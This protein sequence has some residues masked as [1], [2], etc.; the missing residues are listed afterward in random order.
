MTEI[1]ESRVCCALGNSSTRSAAHRAIS[2][3]ALALVPAAIWSLTHR[4]QGL[5]GD[6]GLYAVQA[7]ARLNT[8]LGK[9]VFLSHASQDKFTIF[10]PV[11]AFFIS[12]MGLHTAGVVLL[13]VFKTWFSV[14]AWALCRRLFGARVALLAATLLIITGG[15]YGAYQVFHYL[16]DMLTARS[17]AEALAMTA[18]CLHFYEHRLAALLTAAVAVAVHPLIALPMV[19]LL[20]CLSLPARASA[21]CALAGVGTV[22]CISV[23]AVVAPAV[24]VKWFA[25]MDPAWLDM[26]RERSQFCFLQLWSASD[27]EVNALPFLSLTLSFF[28][29]PDARIRKLIAAAMLVGGV[30][31]LIGLIAGTVGPVALLL[32]GQAWRWDW[33]T[34][35]VSV[36]F[37]APTAVCLWKTD[38]CGPLCAVLLAG[39]WLLPVDV[40]TCFLAPAVAIWLSRR[41][42]PARWGRYFPWMFAVVGIATAAMITAGSWHGFSLPA[43]GGRES[44]ALTVVRSLLCVSGLP[45]ILAALAGYWITTGRSLRAASLIALGLGT[46]TACSLPVALNISGLKRSDAQFEEYS[47]WRQVIPR[48]SNVLVLESYYSAAFAWF[49]LE[50]PSFLTVDQSS[51][52]IFS[53]ATAMEVLHRSE[54]LA[55]VEEPDW[56]LLS[57]RSGSHRGKY[58]ARAL[59]L[60]RDKLTGICADPDLDFVVAREDVGFAPI[61]HTRAADGGTSYLYDCKRVSAP[62]G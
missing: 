56:R 45:I 42:V 2:G 52:V 18:L 34:S 14:A 55:L 12:R 4:Y 19:L 30:G 11:Y 48:G 6:A 26:V 25:V 9:D 21:W 39:G 16:E 61:R 43:E 60:T 57:R 32:Q 7:L 3:L 36:L 27:W 37:L 40:G 38:R 24:G 29:I 47:D 8:G 20:L 13:I 35:L 5:G 58:D 62:A 50:R 41:R 44:R 22:L 59:P 23:G 10:S 46:A 1:L 54:V 51:G 33:V 15:D 31:L 17:L 28:A 49:T 53:R